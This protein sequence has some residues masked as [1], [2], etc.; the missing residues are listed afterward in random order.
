MSAGCQLVVE[1]IGVRRDRRRR[2]GTDVSFYIFIF[3][4]LLCKLCFHVQKNAK[5]KKMCRAV[6]GTPDA[7]GRAVDFDHLDR[8]KRTFA[9]ILGV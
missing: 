3:L 2:V 8:R 1:G 6:G 9:D 5:L 4:Y 7:N